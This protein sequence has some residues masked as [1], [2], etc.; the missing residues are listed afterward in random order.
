MRQHAA[1]TIG[2]EIMS[3]FI[4]FSLLLVGA[5]GFALAT[6]VAAPE[7]DGAS[8]T[9]AIALLS[10]SLLVLRSRRKR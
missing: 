8:A 4:G 7:I 10:G 3:K 1:T 2:G 6:P 5:A 9:T